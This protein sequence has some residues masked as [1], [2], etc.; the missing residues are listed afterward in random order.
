MPRRRCRNDR[1]CKGR[2][3]KDWFGN[4]TTILNSFDH[5]SSFGCKKEKGKTMMIMAIMLYFTK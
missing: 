1:G 4:F 2:V 3:N 5:S